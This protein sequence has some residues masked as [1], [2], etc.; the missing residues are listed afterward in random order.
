[1]WWSSVTYYV[2]YVM[3]QSNRAN[4]SCQ[5]LSQWPS[6]HQAQASCCCQPCVCVQRYDQTN[7]LYASMDHDG[8]SCRLVGWYIATTNAKSVAWWILLLYLDSVLTNFTCSKT[9]IKLQLDYFYMFENVN[10]TSGINIYKYYI[11]HFRF[12]FT[13]H[14]TQKIS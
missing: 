9:L 5:K 2:V 7:I 13:N 8:P 12:L 10:K 4:I 6:P 3:I 14:N 11:I 1:V